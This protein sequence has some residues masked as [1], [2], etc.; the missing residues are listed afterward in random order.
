MRELLAYHRERR[1]ESGENPL[2]E[3]DRLALDKLAERRREAAGA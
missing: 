1:R 3:F 2:A